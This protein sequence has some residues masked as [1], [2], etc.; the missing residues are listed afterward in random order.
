VNEWIPVT[1]SLPEPRAVVMTK[2]DD[3]KGVRNVAPLRL[4]TTRRGGVW[5]FCTSD[6]IAKREDGR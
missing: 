4:V 1:T 5:F 3:A 2:I 6:Q